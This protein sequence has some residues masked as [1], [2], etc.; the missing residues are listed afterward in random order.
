MDRIIE[1]V[2]LTMEGMGVRGIARHLKVERIRVM[3]VQRALGIACSA[4]HHALV[5]GVAVDYVQMDEVWSFVGAKKKTLRRLR[6]KGLP[7]RQDQRGDVWTF[8]ALH[9]ESMLIISYLAGPRQ[10]PF[11]EYFVTDLHSRLANRVMLVSDGLS[12]YVRAVKRVFGADGVDYGMVVKVR[13]KGKFVGSQKYRVFGNP[14]MDLISTNAI[15]NQNLHHRQ[16]LRRMQ[17]KTTGHSKI[18]LAHFANLSLWAAYHNFCHTPDR[19][20]GATPA[21]VAGL[22]QEHW[23]IQR[24]I[25]EAVSILATT[26]YK[27]R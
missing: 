1:I 27:P 25:L 12:Q 15:E 3:Q 24:L 2:E 17:R 14:N 19:L 13:V 20:N 9:P 4:L 8:L 11:T 26:P 23:S 7:I 6:Q 21:M 18:V 22:A 10:Y 16:K 5:R